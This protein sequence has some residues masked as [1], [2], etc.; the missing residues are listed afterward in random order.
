[1]T[2]PIVPSFPRSSPMAPKAQVDP[3]L[4]KVAQQFE[5]V[6]LRQII[7]EMRKGQLAED[8]LGS[9]ATDHFR[10]LADARTADSLAAKGQ[11]GIAAMIERQLAGVAAHA[12]E[13]K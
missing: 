9:S 2:Q 5:A 1:M 4:R 8:L 6:F 13:G 10:E 12:K 11:F 3:A 7:G